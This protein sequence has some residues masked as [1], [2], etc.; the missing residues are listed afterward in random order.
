MIRVCVVEDQTLVRKGLVRLLSLASG[1]EVVGEAGDGE[2]ARD[3]IRSTAP[4]VVLLD[5]RMPKANGLDLLEYL[6][7][8][9]SSPACILLTTFDDDDAVLRGIRLGARGYLLK[10]V[11]LELL[12]EAIRRVSTGETLFNPALTVRLIRELNPNSQRADLNPE[13]NLTDRESEILRLMTGGYSNREI[14]EAL[15]ISEGTVKNHVSNILSKLG[16]RDR[17][18]AVLKAIQHGYV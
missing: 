16:V 7:K 5:V 3:V 12:T 11:T 1:I 14:A 10:D 13:E 8:Q 6:E 2:E 9:Q 4:D 17:T 18:R 15:D